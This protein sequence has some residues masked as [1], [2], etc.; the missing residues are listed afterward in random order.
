V[1]RVPVSIARAAVLGYGI[2]L[3][4]IAVNQLDSLLPSP[5]ALMSTRQIGASL[6]L[7]DMRAGG[8]PLLAEKRRLGGAGLLP[9]EGN[10]TYD[11]CTI[12]LG[13]DPGLY[14]ILPL[15][16]MLFGGDDIVALLRWTFIWAFA[17]LFAL[18]PVWAFEVSRSLGAALLS[19]AALLPALPSLLNSDIY[20][21]SY[22]CLLI[23]LPGLALLARARGRHRVFAA[24]IAALMIL[25]SLASFVRSFAGLPAFL[26]AELLIFME[27]ASWRIR[28]SF[29]AI[30]LVAN[31]IVTPIAAG[32]LVAM[33]DQRI[34]GTVAPPPITTVWHSVYLG[35]GYLSNPYG[36]RYDDNI[37]F[38]H[39]LREDPSL[40]FLGPGYGDTLL[41]LITRIATN[42]PIFIA[43]TVGT[44]VAVVTSHVVSRFWPLLLLL[45][46]AL[47][48]GPRR[49]QARR[50]AL[51]A[52][53]AV[54]YGALPPILVVPYVQYELGLFGGLG[55]LLLDSLVLIVA[56]VEDLIRGRPVRE[57]TVASL[58]RS[59]V[60]ALPERIRAH[61][62]ASSAVAVFLA[63]L[64]LA[65]AQVAGLAVRRAEAA[66]FYRQSETPLASARPGP[67]QEE[68]AFGG[69]LPTG[70]QTLA[71]TELSAKGSVLFVR[72][73][74]RR[75]DYQL[76]GPEID[77]APGNYTVVVDGRV[78]S[79]GLELGILDA[80]KTEWLRQAHFWDGQFQIPDD[81]GREMAL[82]LPLNETTRVKVILSN[83]ATTENRSEWSLSKVRIIR[84]P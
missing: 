46:L 29:A 44:K 9:C 3:A 6:V 26:A 40:R 20:W 69:D 37:A 84:A 41:R 61:L 8:P 60:G 51:L 32:T 66:A 56:Q 70:W 82:G 53:P 21:I 16:A 72:T 47:L 83:W 19:P 59:L 65:L 67:A 39:A 71:G 64:V 55:F 34:V 68:W 1:T 30:A 80:R 62:R 38:E 7:Q 78:G 50:H 12:P 76:I 27:H 17:L 11:N 74:T 4:A 48:V 33:R 25:A 10:R 23:C 63:L 35:L 36:I 22:W 13:D 24:S 75:Y 2:V 31:L 52:I 79:G 28:A 42:D 18:A 49:H 43:E 15:E 54:A 57:W 73:N 5:V 14:V 45:P 58:R 77:L 81:A